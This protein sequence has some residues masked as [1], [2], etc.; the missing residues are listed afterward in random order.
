MNLLRS[1]AV[2]G[3]EFA[4]LEREI[5]R[6]RFQRQSVTIEQFDDGKTLRAGLSA[7]LARDIL[8]AL[9]CREPY[10]LLVVERKWTPDRY[11]KWLGNLLIGA[12]LGKSD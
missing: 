10:R 2:V 8:W 12:L 6:R 11:E 9:T 3:P 5:E 1:S 4:E 7:A